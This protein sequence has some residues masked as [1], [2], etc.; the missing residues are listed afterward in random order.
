M[1]DSPLKLWVS[2]SLHPGGQ[3]Y[4]N[5]HERPGT[6]DTEQGAPSQWAARGMNLAD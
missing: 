2:V 1:P 4:V 5:V 3:L 6:A